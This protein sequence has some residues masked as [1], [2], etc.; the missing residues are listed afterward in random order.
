ML[1]YGST[2]ALEAS[3]MYLP[4]SIWKYICAPATPY[5]NKNLHSASIQSMHNN[6]MIYRRVKF[7]NPAWRC[8]RLYIFL[9]FDLNFIIFMIVQYFLS[10]LLHIL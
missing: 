4:E 7:F 10:E 9:F 3:S 5:S 8:I 2:L 1:C 6:G